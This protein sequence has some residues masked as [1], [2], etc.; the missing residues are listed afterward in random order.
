MTGDVLTL[1]ELRRAQSRERDADTL[2]E[3]DDT[4]F[5]RARNYLEMK[6]APDSHLENQEYRQAKR[7]LED[8]IN[9]RQRKIVKLAFLSVKSNIQ[10]EHLLDHEAS[11]FQQV[12]D[13]VSRHRS[14]IHGTLF[15]DGTADE[16]RAQ[17]G[18][19]VQDAN[20]DDSSDQYTDASGDAG[21][22]ME[23]TAGQSG[24]AD[25]TE[26]TPSA[27]A[28]D[29]SPAPAEDST[30]ADSDTAED[31]A[32]DGDAE[33]DDGADNAEEEP[34][35]SD[36]ADSTNDENGAVTVT[37]TEAVSAFMGVDL[38]AY[39]PFEAGDEAT[40]PAKNADVLV[41]QGKAERPG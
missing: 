26:S 29:D 28:A 13:A 36:E 39:G 18:D 10:V 23:D 31:G 6:A 37:I 33:A 30:G 11:L 9:M 5:D 1:D 27:P 15:D 21:Q 16:Q 22:V 8:I 17:P 38:E 7:I 2:Q 25:T 19:T 40:L 32:A 14:D 34:E 24:G 3:L 12:E 20:Q 4:F 41:E 35:D